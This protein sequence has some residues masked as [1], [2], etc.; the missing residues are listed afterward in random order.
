MNSTTFN[1]LSWSEQCKVAEKTA[2]GEEWVNRKSGVVAVIVSHSWRGVRLRRE[3]G[4]ETVIQHHYFASDYF[5]KGR[6]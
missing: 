2:P 5:P 4:R 1:S 3:S 6:V